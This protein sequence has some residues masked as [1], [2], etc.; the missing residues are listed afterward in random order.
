MQ[1]FSSCLTE[2]DDGLL[3]VPFEELFDP[4]ELF[5]LDLLFDGDFDVADF[6]LDA[7]D[8][9]DL[10]VVELDEDAPEFLVFPPEAITDSLS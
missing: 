2:D 5:E 3:D 4:A 8:A 7:F 1:G 9:V 10:L 6:E